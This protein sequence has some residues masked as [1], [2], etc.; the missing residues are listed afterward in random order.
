MVCE[1]Y[2]NKA[3]TKSPRWVGVWDQYWVPRHLWPQDGP[4]CGFDPLA[5]TPCPSDPLS[6]YDLEQTAAI[7][8]PSAQ[9]LACVKTMEWSY[10]AEWGQGLVQRPLA[11]LGP[12]SCKILSSGQPSWEGLHGQLPSC[13]QR[14]SRGNHSVTFLYTAI[15]GQDLEPWQPRGAVRCAARGGLIHIPAIVNPLQNFPSPW[16]GEFC[17]GF[18]MALSC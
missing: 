1:L 7:S 8:P 14:K 15:R 18:T 3:V 13:P 5:S 4:S 12:N 10:G 2:L 11:S 6:S 16:K 9:D 17:N